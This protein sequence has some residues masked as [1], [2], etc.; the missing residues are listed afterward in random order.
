MRALLLALLLLGCDD[1]TA[2][3]CGPTGSTPCC[4]GDA[5]IPPSGSCSAGASCV[6]IG[7]EPAYSCTCGSDLKWS[8]QV[9]TSQRDL[10]VPRLDATS[11]D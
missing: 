1:D 8:C 10:S 2:P 11:R 3:M 9:R 7:F 5:V 4:P 6:A